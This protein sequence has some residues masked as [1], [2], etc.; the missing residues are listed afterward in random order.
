VLGK[1]KGCVCSLLVIFVLLMVAAFAPVFYF[2]TRTFSLSDVTPESP[3]ISGAPVHACISPTTREY[4]W[5]IVSC[6]ERKSPYF[7][8]IMAAPNPG[9]DFEPQSFV[10]NSVKMK[11]NGFAAC[12]LVSAPMKFQT[13]RAYHW[14]QAIHIP[15]PRFEFRDD[16]SIEIIIEM[17]SGN[18]DRTKA[19]FQF[20]GEHEIAR[21]SLG[22]Q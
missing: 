6:T 4:Q 5:L 21:A 7:L 1:L 8:E 14:A 9:A 17:E 22:M 12:D 15:V 19:R 11:H 13:L 3:T 16:M 10:I 20:T 18:G 2:D